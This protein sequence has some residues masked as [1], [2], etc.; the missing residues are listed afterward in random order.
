MTNNLKIATPISD[1]LL[2]QIVAYL[3]AQA[4]MMFGGNDPAQLAEPNA[5]MQLLMALDSETD[6]EFR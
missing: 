1:A 6:G 5:A 2:R 3:D 4:D